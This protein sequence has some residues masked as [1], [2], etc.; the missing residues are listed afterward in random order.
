LATTRALYV[1]LLL[2]ALVPVLATLLLGRIFCSWVCPAGFLFEITGKLRNVL[3]WA[4]IRPANVKF[5]HA[6]KYVLLVVGLLTATAVGLPIFALVYPPAVVSRL[7]HAW[8]FGTAVTG[9]LVLL[10]LIILFELL[11]SPRWWCR[12]MCPGGALYGLLGWPRLLRVKL[13]ADRCTA[14]RLCEPVCEPGLNPVLQSAGLECDNCGVC[15]HHC[16]EKALR[17]G[18]QRP[19]YELGR[20][21][22]AAAAPGLAVSSRDA[23]DRIDLMP[24]RVIR[25][26]LTSRVFRFVCQAFFVLVFF[27][28]IAAGLFGNQNPALNIAPILTWT[29]WWGGLVILIMYA[30]KAW[31]YV[32]PWDAVAGWMEKMRLWK[33]TDEGLG[34]GLKWP[35]AL[36]NIAIATVLFVGLTWVELGFGVTMKPRVTAYLALAML[37]MAIACA[38]LFERKGF[39]RYACLVGRVSGLY[40]M[41]SGIEIR[42]RDQAVYKGCSGKQCVQGSESAYGCPTFLFPGHL[43]TNAYCIQCTECLQACP[44]DNLAVNLRPWGADLVTDH[45]PRSDEAYL[46]LLMLS[47]TGFHGLTMTPNW[48][49]LTGWL[50]EGLSLSH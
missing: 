40:A 30:G 20:S 2:S 26:L 16:P 15:I 46:A 49:R 11:V 29:V 45:R 50:T 28:I 27:V 43:R 17:F 33:K 19:P 10:G 6:N 24:I 31:C 44:H 47:I 22:G 23:V 3:K 34:L 39:C 5:S 42:P 13:D 4:E 18:R 9:G 14:C 38:F 48:G 36:R 41:F 12:T 7:V 32:C 35:R 37:L 1:P 8:V 25:T 21:V